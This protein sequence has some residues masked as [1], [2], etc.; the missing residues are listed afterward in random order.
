MTVPHDIQRL[1]ENWWEGLANAS[2]DDHLQFAHEFLQKHG[3]T[4]PVRVET[5]AQAVEPT[6]QS[7][8]VREAKPV[9]LA[10]H[11]LPAGLLES[12]GSVVDRRLDFCPIARTLVTATRALDIRYAFVTDGYRFYLYDVRTGELLIH[13]DSP[14]QY[15]T[16]FGDTL[17]EE[18]V[19]AG[20]LDEVRRQ[21]RSYSAR[22]LREWT[23][24]WCEI[25][26]RDWRLPEEAAWTVMD[27]LIVLRYL[28]EHG[29]FNRPGWRLARK[30]VDVLTM[31]YGPTPEGCGTRL[32]ELFGEL[33]RSWKTDLFASCP[34]V[35][36]T[37]DQ[38][39]VT[40]PLLR[41]FV[42][43]SR[44]KFDVPTILESFNHGDASEKARVRMIPEEN[45]QRTTQIAKQSAEIVDELQF[46]LDVADEGYRAIIHW[47][48]ELTKLYSRLGVD[49]EASQ[50]PQ[51]Q[52]DDELDLFGWSAIEEARPSAITDPF[53]HA[54]N[55]GMIIYCATP[56]QM[57]T[58][59]LV[60]YLH[61]I[62]RYREDKARFTAFPN[63]TQ[64]L[65]P[66]PAVLDSDRHYIYR[67][68]QR[69]QQA[70]GE[71]GV[72]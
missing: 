12:P 13:A 44:S 2:S 68:Q 71:W 28:L 60:L 46:E 15:V 14:A 42:L 27:R 72:G 7:F 36:A 47:F 45:P 65:Q 24:R 11:F 4:D 43:L 52:E 9:P 39:N 35:E 30:F 41:E 18:N 33:A 61:L 40:T 63:V 32:V 21:P 6:A 10:A 3:W 53:N 1:C 48:D 49:F 17:F 37:L 26:Q 64:C 54:I 19:A 8:L 20:M 69:Q 5:R 67:S 62:R 50:K 58:A 25:L 22:Q 59:R 66:R 56:I 31:A 34:P 16:E 55:K 70:E 57:R 51:P 38:D 23:H 29:M